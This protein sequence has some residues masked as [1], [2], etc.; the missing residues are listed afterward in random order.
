[1]IFNID[2]VDAEL[3]TA[4]VYEEDG[5]QWQAVYLGT[6][7]SLTPSGKVTAPWCDHRTEEEGEADDA[8]WEQAEQELDTIG[9]ALTSGEGDPCDLYAVREVDDAE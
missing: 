2:A 1:M 4:E 8:W 7:M 6:I 9:A 5:R 3:K